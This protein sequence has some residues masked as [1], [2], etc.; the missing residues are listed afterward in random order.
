MGRKKAQNGEL[1][2]LHFNNPFFNHV[3]SF[4]L[5]HLP[6]VDCGMLARHHE[7]H[8]G[9][10]LDHLLHIIEALRNPCQPNQ[11]LWNLVSAYKTLYQVRIYKNILWSKQSQYK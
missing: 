2:N 6:I 1:V 9:Y 5:P 11:W 8:H 3:V 10:E 4:L 7:D